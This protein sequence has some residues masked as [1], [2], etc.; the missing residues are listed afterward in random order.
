MDYILTQI[1]I[2]VAADVERPI[3]VK[4][5]KQLVM[6]KTQRSNR[7]SDVEHTDTTPQKGARA[8]A[9]YWN[10]AVAVVWMLFK[11]VRKKISGSRLLITQN[12]H[13]PRRPRSDLHSSLLRGK[14]RRT[15]RSGN[16]TAPSRFLCFC[17]FLYPLCLLFSRLG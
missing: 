3:D 17:H 4:N 5:T 9:R 13:Q 11:I 15:G 16:Q 7:P 6:Q 10:G 8:L 2:C 12:T 14:Q 1:V